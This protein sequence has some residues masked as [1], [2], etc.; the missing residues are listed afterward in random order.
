MARA[1]MRREGDIDWWVRST[2]GMDH[3]NYEITRTRKGRKGGGEDSLCILIES[4]EVEIGNL[5]LSHTHRIDPVHIPPHIEHWEGHER[6]RWVKGWRRGRGEGMNGWGKKMMMRRGEEDSVVEERKT[7]ELWIVKIEG[8]RV[9]NQE[10]ESMLEGKMEIERQ[11]E[12]RRGERSVQWKQERGHGVTVQKYW[13]IE[14]DRTSI[15]WW[16]A[17]KG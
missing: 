3:S 2:D 14:Q 8:E 9:S 15:D 17:T 5:W 4:D 11:K 12:E 7:R 13:L 16:R 6:M 10:R 1:L